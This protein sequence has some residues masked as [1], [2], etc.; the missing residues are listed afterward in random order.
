MAAHAASGEHDGF[1][2]PV[3]P[4]KQVIES[5][6]VAQI[7]V[8]EIRFL[9]IGVADGLVVARDVAGWIGRQ[10]VVRIDVD[11][12]PAFGGTLRGGRRVQGVDASV[13]QLDER[14]EFS[15]MGRLGDVAMRVGA[16][17]RLVTNMFNSTPG[18]SVGTAV[19]SGVESESWLARSSWLSQKASKVVGTR[20]GESDFGGGDGGAHGVQPVIAAGV[21]AHVLGTVRKR[22]AARRPARPEGRTVQWR[23]RA[24]RAGRPDFDL[25][26]PEDRSSLPSFRTTALL[27][28][29]VHLI[30]V[31]RLHGTGRHSPA[32][33][34]PDV[35]DVAGVIRR[36]G[37]LL[38]DWESLG[39][40]Q[41]S[42]PRESEQ[43]QLGDARHCLELYVGQRSS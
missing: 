4:G 8:Q 36:E 21:A 23:R 9:P 42:E 17:A 32:H 11:E 31:G 20:R 2:I 10:L 13:L 14:G 19:R 5:A 15:V 24:F 16:R 35:V 25:S 37:E 33:G 1:A 30:G 28:R 40:E 39:E 12:Q 29:M 34:F 22:I 38:V 6:R 7:H 26:L 3:G 43:D 18:T 27:R 41:A